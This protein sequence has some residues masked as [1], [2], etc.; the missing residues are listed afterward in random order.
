MKLDNFE[1]YLSG[2]SDKEIP[3]YLNACG[4]LYGGYSGSLSNGE[5]L[6]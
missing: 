5:V 2:N 3:L 6:K 1:N 4:I